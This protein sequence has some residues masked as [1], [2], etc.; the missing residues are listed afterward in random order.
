MKEDANSPTVFSEAVM[1]A[2]VVDANENREVTIVDIPNAFIQTV[3]KDE[4]D[5]A[6]IRIRC[7][8]VDIL[9]SIVRS[10][11]LVLRLGMDAHHA[12]VAVGDSLAIR[13][14][15]EKGLHILNICCS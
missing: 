1:L 11:H 4:K 9:V 7:P 13:V 15:V 10:H 6:F 12:R 8:L 14:F 5:R 2:Y 3:V